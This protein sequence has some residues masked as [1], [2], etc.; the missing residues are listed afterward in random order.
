MRAHWC[1]HGQLP[2]IN[3]S[4]RQLLLYWFYFFPPPHLL[5]CCGLRCHFNSPCRFS[6]SENINS[7]QE[8]RKR[9]SNA[10]WYFFFLHPNETRIQGCK[11]CMQIKSTLILAHSVISTK[12]LRWHIWKWT[13]VTQYTCFICV[14]CRIHLAVLKES[15]TF[16]FAESGFKTTEAHEGHGYC[17]E[18]FL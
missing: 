9:H 8:L 15:V 2:F 1:W 13:F 5:A 3:K 17:N 4:Y 11:I 18:A 14:S 6:K 16:L 7:L 12:R 10:S